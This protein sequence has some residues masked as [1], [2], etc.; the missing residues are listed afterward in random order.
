MT[1]YMKMHENARGRV[2]AVCD[3]DIHGKVFEE[4]GRV[5]D[6]KKH[7]G[8]YKG[9]S[10]G[11]KEV[12]E[13]LKKFTSLNIAG[14]KAVALAIRAEVIEESQVLDIGGVPHAQAYKI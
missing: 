2:V 12:L 7:G 4:G 1:F 3:K 13:A 6:L 11:E 10:A 8:F 5:L 9:S 14:K